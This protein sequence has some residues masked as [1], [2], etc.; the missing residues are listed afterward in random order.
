ML[1]V[2]QAGPSQAQQGFG[3]APAFGG[4]QNGYGG[5][6]PSAAAQ[7]AA[8]QQQPAPSS[9]SPYPG[10]PGPQYP[11]GQQVGCIAVFTSHDC[12][13]CA[14]RLDIACALIWRHPQAWALCVSRL[15][16]LMTWPVLWQ[17]SWQQ[18]QQPQQYQSAPPFQQQQQHHQEAPKYQQ[19]QAQQ[20]QPS[21]CPEQPRQARA[22]HSLGTNWHRNAPLCSALDA[23]MPELEA[24]LTLAHAHAHASWHCAVQQA[25]ANPLG[26]VH[27]DVNPFGAPEASFGQLSLGGQPQGQHSAAQHA[28]WGG[29]APTSGVTAH[30]EAAGLQEPDPFADL[31]N[32]G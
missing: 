17:D 8:Y 14:V 31:F 13:S 19:P 11:N 12:L 26:A 24:L 32:R 27:R 4:A 1:Y 7:F 10:A 23:W 28:G 30:K 18:Q 29:P 25:A 22:M 2:L 5:P 6:P 3:Q 20:S 21:R 15:Q 9:Q 16:A